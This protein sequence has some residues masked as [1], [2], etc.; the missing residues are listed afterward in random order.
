MSLISY[1]FTS[2]SNIIENFTSSSIIIDDVP[3]KT[4]VHSVYGKI[5][6]FTN[7]DCVCKEILSGRVWEEHL[8]NDI[9]KKYILNNTS[10]IDCGTFIGSHTILM[11]K[12][13]RNNDLFCFEMMPQHYKLLLDNIKLNNLSNVH[14]FNCAIGDTN[15]SII[16]PDI[17]YMGSDN[18]GAISLYNSKKSDIS[19]V[20]MTLDY[21]LPFITKPLSFIKMDIEGNEILAL[22]GA[23]NLLTKYRPVILI[24]LWEETYK[25]LMIDNIWTFLQ[26]LGYRITHIS[27]ADY[28]LSIYKPIQV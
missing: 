1:T 12:L 25:N 15:G 17:D 9:F 14:T 28:L 8:Y 22:H 21:I 4:I 11:K 3:T 16:L 10:L 26:N 24:E 18:Y 20:K 6:C 19:V 2:K 23:K 5:K 27:G 13:N 7:D